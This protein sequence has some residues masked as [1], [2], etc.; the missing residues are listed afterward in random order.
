MKTGKRLGDVKLE[1]L[2]FDHLN[3]YKTEGRR[4]RLGDV[5]DSVV[6]MDHKKVISKIAYSESFEKIL[7]DSESLFYFV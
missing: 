5:V 6:E 2:C 7:N 4:N 3:L 1:S